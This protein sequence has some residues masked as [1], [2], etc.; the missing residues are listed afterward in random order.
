MAKPNEPNK[1]ALTIV[2]NGQPTVVEANLNSPL[3]SVIGKALEATGNTGQPPESWELRNAAGEELDLRK[4]IREFHFPPGVQLFL[5]LK[6]GVGGSSPAAQFA[7]PAVSRAKF[8]QEVADFRDLE[9]DYR[10]RGWFLLESEFPVVQLLLATDKLQGPPAVV[11][12]V[13]FD[14]T[15]YDA[16]PPSVQLVN[17]FTSEPYAAKDLPVNLNRAMPGQAVALP[18]MPGN[19]QI[20]GAQPLMQ[21]HDPEEVPFLCLAGVREYHD[22]PGHSGD[23]W[24]LHRASGAGRL[25][26]LLEIIHRYGIEPIRG[27][28]VNLVPQVALDQGEPPE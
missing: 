25:V 4:K 5:N 9:A 2:V 12:G 7:E 10:S 28:A 21:A 27:Y 20:Q 26:R 19:L 23:S 8:E 18:G 6:A 24:E 17:P 1:I 16:A 13:R 22:H 14:Y 11:A 15:N 3:R